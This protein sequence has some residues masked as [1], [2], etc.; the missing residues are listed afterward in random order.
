MA[1]LTKALVS[2]FKRFR[3]FMEY[4]SKKCHNNWALKKI[5]FRTI[6]MFTRVFIGSNSDRARLNR[7]G[8]DRGL[9]KREAIDCRPNWISHGPNWNR[10]EKSQTGPDRTELSCYQNCELGW[11]RKKTF[12]DMNILH[13]FRYEP[14]Q[15]ISIW[16][17]SIFVN[18]WEITSCKRKL[19]LNK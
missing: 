12:Y 6:N 15:H 3:T 9:N 17:K 2:A 14:F 16:K 11:H 18:I 13:L 8:L 5:R 19:K 1:E 7:T 4:L 10:I